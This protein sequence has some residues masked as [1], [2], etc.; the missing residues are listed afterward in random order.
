MKIYD[1]IC[2]FFKLIHF[3]VHLV[4]PSSM[5]I[6]RSKPLMIDSHS[7]L[8]DINDNLLNESLNSNSDSNITNIT[9]NDSC[10][11]KRAKMNEDDLDDFIDEPISK[12]LRLS[13]LDHGYITK[14]SK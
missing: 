5:G 4:N 13:P 1:I 12:H 9:N 10:N 11:N 6:K 8:T 7:T 2:V 3:L 14:V